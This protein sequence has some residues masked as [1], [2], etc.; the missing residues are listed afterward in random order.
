MR[1]F[2]LLFSVFVLFA[3]VPMAPAQRDRAGEASH[4]LRG[5]DEDEAPGRNGSLARRQVAGL[6]RHHR[7][8]R[9]K[10]KNRRALAEAISGPDSQKDPQKAPQKL[11][12]AQP[13]DSGPQFSPDGKH[14]LF[15][16]H[17]DGS[18]KSGWPTSTP[19]P[20]QPPTRESSP[21][22]RQQPTTPSGRPTGTPCFSLPPSIP[23]VPPIVA[24]DASG[25][26]CNAGRAP[27]SH[28][29]R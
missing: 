9:A 8:P 1:K 6:F 28:P 2:S 16:S 24:N 14:I 23:T 4:D 22:I 5:H 20:A 13:G 21:T 26:K 19:P 29:A 27:L 15:V 18:N 10:Y 12:V 17:R 3:A 11:A 7:Q 25:D